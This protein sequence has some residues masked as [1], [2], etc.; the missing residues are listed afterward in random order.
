MLVQNKGKHV[1]HA[2]GVMVIPGANQIEDAAWKKFSGHP[3]M[4]KLISA[5]EIEAMGQA[6]TTKDLKADKAIALVKDTFDVSLLTE[7]RA[8]EDR[9]TVLEAIDAQL[10]EL[11]GEGNPNGTPDGDE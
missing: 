6:Q 3:L 1:R 2:A 10:A 11:Q 8:A 7:W 4:K 9:T 5:G